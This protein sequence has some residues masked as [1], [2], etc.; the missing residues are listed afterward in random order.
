MLQVAIAIGGVAQLE[1][2][3]HI[4]PA[5]RKYSPEVLHW[6]THVLLGSASLQEFYG[7]KVWAPMV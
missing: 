5:L 7:L 6:Q 4:F 2:Y 1:Y 3:Y